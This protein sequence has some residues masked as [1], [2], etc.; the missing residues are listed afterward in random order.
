MIKSSAHEGRSWKP[1]KTDD[2]LER[3]ALRANLDA[4]RAV[5]SATGQTVTHLT[6]VI[7]VR[8][9]TEGMPS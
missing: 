2:E 5:A 1:S 3:D 4:F 7:A 6:V 8:P 9:T